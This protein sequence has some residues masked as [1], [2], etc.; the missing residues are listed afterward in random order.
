MP[1]ATKLGRMMTY[2]EGLSH[3]KRFNYV[4]TGQT[5]SIMFHYH[6]T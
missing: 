1:V 5:K 4:D 3:I 6:N 2:H